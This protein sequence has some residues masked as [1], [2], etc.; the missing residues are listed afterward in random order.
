MLFILICSIHVFSIYFQAT[1]LTY[2]TFGLIA[3][4]LGYNIPI[5]Y[6]NT[7]DP[8]KVGSDA[9]AYDRKTKSYVK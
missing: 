6:Y 4:Y 3:L 5:V 8:E 9:V 7:K 1:A 2:A